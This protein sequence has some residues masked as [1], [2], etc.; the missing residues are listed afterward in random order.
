MAMVVSSLFLQRQPR[1]TVF[2]LDLGNRMIKSLRSLDPVVRFPAMEEEIVTTRLLAF[3][4]SSFNTMVESYVG[5]AAISQS[6]LFVRMREM[7]S[8]SW[9][10]TR[11]G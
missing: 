9:I 2:G 11:E 10:S 1:L 5:K 8:I 4:D 6:C 7:L 3:S